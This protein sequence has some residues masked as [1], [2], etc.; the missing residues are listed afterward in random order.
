MKKLILL[1]I[2]LLFINTVS[3]LNQEDIIKEADLLLDMMEYGAAIDNYL[4][5]LSENPGLQDIRKKIGYAY[6][7]DKNIDD[8]LKYIKEELESFPDNEDAYDL[9]IYILYKLSKLHEASNFLAKHNILIRL[10]E[11]NS[12]IG[13]LGCFTLGMFFKEAKIYEKAKKYFR[14]ALEKNHDP[15]K[16][17]VQ[18]IDIELVRGRWE[19]AGW[20]IKEAEDFSGIQPEFY[21]L[22]G[23]GCFE[24]SKT[25]LNF[26]PAAIQC[27]KKALELNP[28]F[29]DA[30][31]NLSCI[32]YNRNDFKKASEYF[33]RVLEIEPESDKTRFYLDCSL[34]KLSRSI[35]KELF[36]ECPE[37]IDL[38]REFIER[39]DREYKHKSKNEVN[40]V[41][42][43]INYLGL[44]FIK[45]GKFHEAIRRFRNGLKI[46]P[47]S[48][49][50]N[51]NLGMVYFWQNNLKEAEKHALVALR[52]RDFFGRVPAY[53][54]QKIRK[55][56]RG[57]K[58]KPL[59]IH[60]SEWT[61]DAA[62]REGNY[63]LDAY[64]FLGTIYFQKGELDKSVLAYKKVIE[65]NHED[66][67]GH[68]NLGC[69]YLALEDRKNAEMEWRR[70]IKYEE[71]LERKKE[72]G[73]ISEDQ[74]SFSLVVFRR[75]VAFRAHKLLGR[76]YLDRNLS[77]KALKE[78]KKAIELEPDDPEP[79]YELGKIYHSKSGQNEK[80]I[81]KAVFYYEK[82]LYLGGEK[83]KEVKE[84]L[85]S[86]K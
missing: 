12:H 49:E 19:F 10:T 7:Q 68:Y 83:E 74:L 58:H 85:K 73:E 65:I 31:F 52:Q 1:F 62:L 24:K 34:K 41:L 32:Y 64:D 40:F 78:F 59:K 20:I 86:L 46:S 81:E 15:V 55:K 51:F 80:Y 84:L 76:L 27:F 71:T 77:D 75:P 16:C 21:C 22:S 6:F 28:F 13:G 11:E 25:N 53:I 79:Y 26:L 42:E 47:E 66:P 33:K 70:A 56:K 38:S 14:K 67:I 29:L 61:F 23:I 44:E 17:F 3:Y 8:A 5:V 54:E 50:I 36:S 82:Y 9:L 30:L 69:A 72:R 60:L 37:D 48:P 39:A 43:N 4:K 18:L 63:F 45:T 57:V 35:D 2:A